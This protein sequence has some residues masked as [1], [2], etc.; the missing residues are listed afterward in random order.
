MLYRVPCGLQLH[1]KVETMRQ[2]WTAESPHIRTPPLCQV[3]SN[4]LQPPPPPPRNVQHFVCSLICGALN[5]LCTG[6]SGL[7]AAVT[8]WV[9]NADSGFPRW[10]LEHLNP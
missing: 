1:A 4:S 3:H 5:S 9:A 6:C 7:S 2:L 10:C 8:L